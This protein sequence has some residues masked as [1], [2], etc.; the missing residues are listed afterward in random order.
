MRELQ[1]ALRVLLTA[2][3]I[4]IWSFGTLWIGWKSIWRAGVLVH[5]WREINTEVRFCARGHA[6]PV[7]GVWDCACGSRI[8]GWAFAACPICHETAAYVPCGVCGLPVK[9]SLLL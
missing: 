1:S 4:V 8:E 7:F 3:R 6:V 5:R 2:M 9:N